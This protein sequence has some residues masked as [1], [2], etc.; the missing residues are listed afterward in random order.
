MT[1]NVIQ[2]PAKNIAN[3]FPLTIEQSL[4]H[5]D[6]V[7]KDYCDEV[8]EDAVEAVFSVLTSY[9]IHVKPDENA[10]KYI[11]FME[12]AIK[13]LLYSVKK[14]PHGFQEVA[15]VSITINDDAK[16]EMDRLISES[17]D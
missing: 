13:S 12:E 10:I 5:L 9:G 4:E 3:I 11:V 6:E 8:A 14:L 16:E 7:R 1:D 2:F 17:V 15:Q